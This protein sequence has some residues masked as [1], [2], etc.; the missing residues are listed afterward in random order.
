MPS[1]AGTDI[2]SAIQA[3]WQASP[4]MT[5]LTSD[6]NLWAYEAPET[7]GLP[8]ATVLLVSEPVDTWTTSYPVYRSTIQINLH[9]NT[10]GAARTLAAQFRSGLENQPLVINGQAVMHILPDSSA[11]Q[12]GEGLGPKGLDCWVAIETFESLFT[13]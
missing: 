7:T 1:Y 5:A 2:L 6:R 3:W 8:Y 9:A 11:L 13:Q 4:S 12:V 10:A